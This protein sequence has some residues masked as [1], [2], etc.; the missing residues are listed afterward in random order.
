MTTKLCPGTATRQPHILQ[1][2][3]ENFTANKAR[4]DGLAP[5]CRE[6]AAE[7]QRLWKESNQSKVKAARKR[8]YAEHGK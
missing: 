2:S 1:A 7:R 5:Y 4:T 3:T 6:C 8:Y